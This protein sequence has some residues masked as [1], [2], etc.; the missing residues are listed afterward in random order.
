MGIDPMTHK[1]KITNNLNVASASKYIANLSHMAEWESARLEAE[2]RLI[3]TSSKH[4]NKIPLHNNNNHSISQQLPY[5]QLPCLNILKA[6]QRTTT[7]LPTINDISAIL[8]NNP[9]N[10]N[11]ESSIPSTLNSSEN[12]FVNDIVPTTTT[13]VGVFR[14][15]PEY[16]QNSAN[17][18]VLDN[19]MGS[20]SG[21]FEDNKF[22]WNYFSNN[23]V[24]S[25]IDPP[26]F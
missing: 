12:L 1:P 17:E 7:K 15:F 25:S 16:T 5:Y 24:N 11:L 18:Q 2:A 4:S 14:V 13:K 22:N 23:L 8:L 10:N 20:C 9:R 21:D 3:G 26:V 6:W 19:F